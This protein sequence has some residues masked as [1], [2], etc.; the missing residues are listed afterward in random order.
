MCIASCGHTFCYACFATWWQTRTPPTCPNCRV[1]VTAS[2]VYLAVGEPGEPPSLKRCRPE[3]EVSS[4][5]FNEVHDAC[6]R[7]VLRHAER[8]E[9]KAVVACSRNSVPQLRARLAHAR[10]EA[11]DCVS[12]ERGMAR[13]EAIEAFR[14]GTAFVIIMDLADFGGGIDLSMANLVV[15]YPRSRS[16]SRVA[17]G[18]LVSGIKRLGQKYPPRLTSLHI[19]VGFADDV[20]DFLF[21]H[22]SDM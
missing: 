9:G 11:V 17:S 10:V 20:D 22:E 4:Y 1:N 7:V 8:G 13:G 12:V 6:V 15:H 16:G 3:D 19:P 21:D 14:T 18:D 5:E 2:D